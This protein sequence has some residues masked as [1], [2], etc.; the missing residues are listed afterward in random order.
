MPILSKPAFSVQPDSSLTPYPFSHSL[1]PQFTNSLFSTSDVRRATCFEQFAQGG[2]KKWSKKCSFLL[3]SAQKVPTF[4]NFCQF[5]HIFFIFLE[6]TCAFD[7]KIRTPDVSL[8][9]DNIRFCIKNQIAKLSL[10]AEIIVFSHK[11][12]FLCNKMALSNV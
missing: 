1:I 3:I 4:A 10:A 8:Y 12:P 7:S 9:T 2:T 6:K 5:L 11:K